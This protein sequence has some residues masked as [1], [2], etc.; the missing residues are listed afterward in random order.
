MFHWSHDV[1]YL[2]IL[3]LITWCTIYIFLVSSKKCQKC[4]ICSSYKSYTIIQSYIFH[5]LGGYCLVLVEL[6]HDL[7]S[8]VVLIIISRVECVFGTLHIVSNCVCIVAFYFIYHA[9]KYNLNIC[10]LLFLVIVL[11]I[12]LILVKTELKDG[13]SVNTSFYLAFVSQYSSLRSK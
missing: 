5:L 8:L 11:M 3:S 10:C 13:M 9:I 4:A 7:V 2:F 12:S 1:P 6:F